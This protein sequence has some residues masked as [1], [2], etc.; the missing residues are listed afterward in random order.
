MVTAAE[1]LLQQ[2]SNNCRNTTIIRQTTLAKIGEGAMKLNKGI[3]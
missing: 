2:W 3:F 1:N